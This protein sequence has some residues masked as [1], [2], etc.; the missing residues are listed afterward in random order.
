M[1]AGN[2]KGVKCA[3]PN[4]A[5]VSDGLNQFKVIYSYQTTKGPAGMSKLAAGPMM[6]QVNAETD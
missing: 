2:G 5:K 3:V 4:W 1:N 6:Y